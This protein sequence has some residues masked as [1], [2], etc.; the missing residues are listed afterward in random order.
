M[1]AAGPG[2]ARLGELVSVNEAALQRV[3]S[4]A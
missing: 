3:H 4:E 1:L 2:C